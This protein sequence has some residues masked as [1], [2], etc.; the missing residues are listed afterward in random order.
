MVLDWVSSPDT[1]G[2]LVFQYTNINFFPEI[3]SNPNFLKY[4]ELVFRQIILTK[5]VEYYFV[6]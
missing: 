1:V 2:F 4:I 3:K 6:F 5:V